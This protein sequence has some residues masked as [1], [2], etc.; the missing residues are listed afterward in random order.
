MIQD[1]TM[2]RKAVGAPIS[3]PRQLPEARPV[4]LIVDGRQSADGVSMTLAF[5]RMAYAPAG[6]HELQ[7]MMSVK[8]L[9]LS[10]E[11]L[12]AKTDEI[13]KSLGTHA[14]RYSNC[15]TDKKKNELTQAFTEDLRGT[16]ASY[17]KW[18]MPKP[19]RE[20]LVN[21]INA[22]A[23]VITVA[24]H[25][26]DIPWEL[27][28]F[29]TGSDCFFLAERAFVVRIPIVKDDEPVEQQ[30]P[31]YFLDV[32]GPV[33][34]AVVATDY[35]SEDSLRRI[36]EEAE[37]GDQCQL[38]MAS[39]IRD[40]V[41][42]IEKGR[43]IFFIGELKKQGIAVGA[44]YWTSDTCDVYLFPFEAVVFLLACRAGFPGAAK[45]F[46]GIARSMAAKTYLAS[47]C[48]TMAPLSL[49]PKSVAIEILRGVSDALICQRL[50]LYEAW[51]VAVRDRTSLFPLF[52]AAF[53]PWHRTVCIKGGS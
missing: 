43:L 2:V 19:I 35:V 36:I 41:R 28:H 47:G 4:T 40:V 10:K 48:S 44:N 26:M 46:C 52:F 11:D 25:A 31:S 27:L 29:G 20:Y 8:S 51:A 16:L 13:W 18:L 34:M 39:T 30:E 24:T 45:Q 33:P 12:E 7:H 17:T 21:E 23:R 53:G 22:G 49:L 6:H 32:D 14:A 42:A 15:K 37:W 3:F 5:T 9:P 50:P 38:S 1:G